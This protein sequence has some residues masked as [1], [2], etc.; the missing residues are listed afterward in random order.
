MLAGAFRT[1]PA[2][3][4]ATPQPSNGHRETSLMDEPPGEIVAVR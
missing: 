1:C 2:N 3:C 4:E